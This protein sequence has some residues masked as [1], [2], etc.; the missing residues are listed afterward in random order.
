MI[1]T[2]YSCGN[3][4]SMTESNLKKILVCDKYGNFDNYI[5][6]KACIVPNYKSYLG[7]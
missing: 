6:D 1:K 4:F 3:L 7:K 2:I 5:P